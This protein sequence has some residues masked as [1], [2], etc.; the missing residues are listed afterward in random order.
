[1][2]RCRLPGGAHRPAGAWRRRLHRRARPRRLADES[3]CAAVG[4]G[5]AGGAPK[6][7]PARPDRFSGA[8]MLTQEQ[9]DLARTVRS[10]LDR[11]SGSAQVRAAIETPRG[12]DEKLWSVLC[13]QIGVAGLAVPE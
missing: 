1:R 11:Q 5:H 9:T 7:S 3:P 6:A 13:E 4:L 12:Y 10:L 8:P 2:R